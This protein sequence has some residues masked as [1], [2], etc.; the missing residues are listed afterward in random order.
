MG[1]KEEFSPADSKW[2]EALLGD[3][4]QVNVSRVGDQESAQSGVDASGNVTIAWRSGDREIKARMYSVTGAPLASEVAVSSK[5]KGREELVEVD[6]SGHWR[7]YCALGVLFCPMTSSWDA[8][9]GASMR[10]ALPR[11]A[12]PWRLSNDWRIRIKRVIVI[13][14]GMSDF[15]SGDISVILLHAGSYG[16]RHRWSGDFTQ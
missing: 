8:I 14:H 2:A 4:F 1:T 3:E 11:A 16:L 7:V 13:G 10:P 5:V 6:C 15:S 12:K 9:S